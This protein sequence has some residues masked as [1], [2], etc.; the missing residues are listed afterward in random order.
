MTRGH[1]TSANAGTRMSAT[2]R[3]GRVWRPAARA[4]QFCDRPRR[5]D[6]P[7]AGFAGV[8][9]AAP[10]GRRAAGASPGDTRPRRRYDGRRASTPRPVT[11]MKEPLRPG[12]RRLDQTAGRNAARG[13]AAGTNQALDWENLAEEIED[14]GRSVGTPS[15]CS[16]V[17][18]IRHLVKLEHSPSLDPRSGWR[19]SIRGGRTELQSCCPRTQPQDRTGPPRAEAMPDTI[20][21]RASISTITAKSMRGRAG[22]AKRYS[23]DQSSRRLVSAGA[24]AI[25][26]G[27]PLTTEAGVT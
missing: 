6:R 15:S 23:V 27:R 21:W 24:G 16:S 5:R 10:V 18:I 8:L 11:D 12:F 9:A 20:D 1:L 19:E 25:L 4:R 14:L 13:R 2:A 26:P 7:E 3:R 22:S 17:R